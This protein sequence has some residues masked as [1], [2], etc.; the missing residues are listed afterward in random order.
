MSNIP[1]TLRP[2]HTH[3]EPGLA[4][5][6]SSILP[7]TTRGIDGVMRTVNGTPHR[8]PMSPGSAGGFWKPSAN[9]RAAIAR[10]NRKLS[11]VA[12]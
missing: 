12:S 10:G 4:A 7:S 5:L 11:G 3:D 2:R 1:Q 8:R 6:Q 9:V